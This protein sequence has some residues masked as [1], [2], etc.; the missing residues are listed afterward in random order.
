MSATLSAPVLEAS[1]LCAGFGPVPLLREIDL[2]VR[3][4]EIVGLLGANGAGKTT[5]IMALAGH[6]RPAAGRVLLGGVPAHLPAYRRARQGLG[7]VTQERCAFM[8]LSLRDNLRLG[9]GGADPVLQ[10][11]PELAPHMDRRVGLL[12]GGQQQ[13]LAVGR[14]LVA[15]PKVL[16]SDEL[17]F[18]LAPQIVDRI[19]QT[20][21]AYAAAHNTAVL[22]VEQQ[23]QKALECVDRAYVLQR[24][25]I[26][27]AETADYLKLHLDELQRVYMETE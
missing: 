26:V 17:S 9:S 2:V 3:P 11:F 5:T 20:L 25:R 15:K 27:L 21:R 13:M 16:L 18:G 10:L 8:D 19:L 24:G 12:S 7:L 6:L 23:V 4:G 1:G 22:L 14:A